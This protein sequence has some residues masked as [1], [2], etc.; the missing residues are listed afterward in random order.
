MPTEGELSRIARE[1][2]HQPPDPR[3]DKQLAR[4]GSM[5]PPVTAEPRTGQPTDREVELD[6]EL[7]RARNDLR[8]TEV[9]VWVLVVVVAILAVTV[10]VLLLR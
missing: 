6:L 5:D 9:I 3:L 1:A 10:V 7:E 2:V 4:L 8:R